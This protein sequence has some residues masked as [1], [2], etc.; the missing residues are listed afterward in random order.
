RRA[1]YATSP[2]PLPPRTPQASPSTRTRQDRIIPDVRTFPAISTSA[3]PRSASSCVQQNA[4]QFVE[5]RRQ[6]VR[7][8]VPDQMDHEVTVQATEKNVGEKLGVQFGA[9]LCDQSAD[10]SMPGL[11]DVTRLTLLWRGILVG[12]DQCDVVRGEIDDGIEEGE[13]PVRRGRAGAE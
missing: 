4:D 3:V 7:I 11:V 13:Q 5:C 6:P 10:V 9:G 1:Y 2:Q 8:A 12:R